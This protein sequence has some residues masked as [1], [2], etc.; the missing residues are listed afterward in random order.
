M[1]HSYSVPH[2]PRKMLDLSSKEVEDNSSTAGANVLLK[3]QHIAGML[4]NITEKMLKQI[5]S[6]LPFCFNGA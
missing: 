6:I 2:S 3:S 5:A 1:G 4:K